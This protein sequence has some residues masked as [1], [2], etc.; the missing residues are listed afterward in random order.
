MVVVVSESHP[1]LTLVEF[2]LICQFLK[3]LLY[4]LEVG[5]IIDSDDN[6]GAR[7]AGWSKQN[8][9]SRDNMDTCKLQLKWQ[10]NK[11]TGAW[12]QSDNSQGGELDFAVF[13]EK[14]KIKRAEP[15]D[16]CKGKLVLC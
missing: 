8:F 1:T 5:K 15:T 14:N 12:L 6:R 3:Y 9:R 11:E 7:H 10:E 2:N 16:V 13:G 4:H